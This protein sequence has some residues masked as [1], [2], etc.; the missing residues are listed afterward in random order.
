MRYATV[1]MLLGIVLS[2]TGLRA[3]IWGVLLAWLGLNFLILGLAYLRRDHGVF[4]KRPDGTIPLWSW[5]VFFP[6]LTYTLIAWH[7]IRLLSR[8]ARLNHVSD[9]LVVGRRL[10][11]GEISDEFANY[12]D[13][14]SEL[15]ELRVARE[16]PGF[17]A[18]PILD[19]SAPEPDALRAAVSRLRPGR[20][21]VHCA[22]GHGRTGLFAL[23]ALLS[24]GAVRNVEEGLSLLAR[25]RPAIHLSPEQR[26]C[27]QAFA[28][29]SP[30][31]AGS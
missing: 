12:I 8:E 6:L 31:G 1:L 20:T 14:T 25:S 3:G 10:L 16:A 26:N 19:A 24:T 11:P 5:L 23:A 13:L 2:A 28:L 4:G 17:M 22:Q 7:L 21:F 27:I 30:S 9:Q 29:K 15:Q 18:F